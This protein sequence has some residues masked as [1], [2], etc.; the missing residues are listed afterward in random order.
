MHI[1]AAQKA[2]VNRG[3]PVKGSVPQTFLPRPMSM[4]SVISILE[5]AIALFE[6][7][8]GA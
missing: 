7:G 6:V 3:T 4:G 2:V 8:T 1:D 5:S